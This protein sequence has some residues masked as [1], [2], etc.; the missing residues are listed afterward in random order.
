MSSG[1]T[2]PRFFVGLHQPSDAKHFQDC[3]ISVH[4]LKSRRSD[5]V[6]RNWIMDCG[7]FSTIS[8]HG[9]YPHPVKEYADHISRWS[10][11][12]TLAA[13][14]SQDYMCEPH[15]LAITG[16]SVSDHQRLTIGRYKELRRLVSGTYILPVLQG[17]EPEDYV[18]HVRQYAALL[19][20]MAW[21][22]VGS[23]CKRNG[24]PRAIENVLLAIKEERPDLR[25]HGFRTEDDGIAVAYRPG[26][27]LHVRFDGLEFRRAQGRPE[28]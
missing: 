4:R 13:A 7:G 19:E 25:L 6:V 15:M 26:L 27:P 1:I 8:L 21:V 9:G 23:I 16:L 12:G 28:C 18:S 3:F 20:P 11:C 14:V 10:R 17:Y 24:N 22:G 2:E 5:F